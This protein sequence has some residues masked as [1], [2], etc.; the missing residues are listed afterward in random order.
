MTITFD[1]IPGSTRKPGQYLEFNTRMAVRTLPGNLQTMLIIAPLMKSGS[2]K[3]LELH[4]VFSDDEAASLF[5]AG[6]LAHLMARAAI[7]SYDYLQLQVI[8]LEEHSAGQA[9][10]GTVTLTGPATSSGTVSLWVSNMRIDVAIDSQDS[11]DTMHTALAA[12][13]NAESLLPVTATVTD[14]GGKKVTLTAKQKGAFGNDILLSVACSAAGV[15]VTPQAMS[16]GQNN[17]DIQ[18]ALDA[19]FAAGHNIIAAPYSDQA[20]LSALREHL[21]KTGGAME[22]RGAVGAAGWPG[23]LSTG[24]TLA[25][26]INDGRTTLAW[27]PGSRCLAGVIAAAYG[28]VIASEEDPARP[29][30]SLPLAG[31]DVTPLTARAGRKEQE[32][33]LHNGLTPL[34]I[35]PGD[36]VQ[37]VRAITTY[38]RNPQN[39]EDPAL[40][41]LTTIRTL[42]Y[43]RK[44]CR[45]RIALRFP[46]EKLHDRTRA[47]VKSELLDV[48]LKLEEEEI[49]ENVMANKNKLLVERNGKD[50]NRLDAVIPADVVNGLHVFA[51]RVDLY[52]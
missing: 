40:L 17:P 25:G 5:G 8:G 16:G 45:E 50:A 38:T 44:A 23:T 41:D 52:L 27:H 47:K 46:R 48:L 24:T 32:N 39:V 11:A 36:V 42:D 51:G 22:Q 28:A 49:L 2:A 31:L 1:T 30:N 9:A 43:T 13:I 29:L 35:G 14:S 7:L 21:K 34:E 10:T 37:I 15:T 12:A 33:A 4:N 26:Q 3:P 6:S 20:T 18:P 19:V